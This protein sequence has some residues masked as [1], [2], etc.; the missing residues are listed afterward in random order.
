MGNLELEERNTVE[1]FGELCRNSDFFSFIES[2][3][4]PV[5]ED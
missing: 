3:D 1:N 4:F 2:T 5:E